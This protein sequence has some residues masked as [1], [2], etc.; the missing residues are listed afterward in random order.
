[1]AMLNQSAMMSSS[2]K[3]LCLIFVR[4][5]SCFLLPSTIE[6][7]F[8]IKWKKLRIWLQILP[9]LK[10]VRTRARFFKNM[11]QLI[12]MIIK[13]KMVVWNPHFLKEHKISRM[14]LKVIVDQDQMKLTLYQSFQSL[15]MFENKQRNQSKKSY[16]LTSLSKNLDFLAMMW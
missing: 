13:L 1:M 14:T 10:Q 6:K 8:S 12:K 2:K 9:L 11:P 7:K 3:Y 15:S 16:W 5:R 4:M